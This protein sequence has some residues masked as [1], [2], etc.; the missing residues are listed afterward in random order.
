MMQLTNKRINKIEASYT[1]EG[2]VL[3]NVDT[4]KYLG[5]TITNDL[6]GIPISPISV[7]KP[8]EHLDS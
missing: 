8:T 6:S 2:T 1:F 7:L 4:I 3:E 5:V